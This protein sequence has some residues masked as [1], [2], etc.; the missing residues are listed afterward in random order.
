MPE[1]DAVSADGCAETDC[2]AADL[3]GVADGVIAL[4]HAAARHDAS[5]TANP[6]VIRCVLTVRSTMV[7]S[8]LQRGGQVDPSLM[9]GW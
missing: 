3:S 9:R 4:P 7:T 5:R 2:A 6:L 1:L 8:N